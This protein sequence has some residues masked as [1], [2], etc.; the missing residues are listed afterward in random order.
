VL[1][2]KRVVTN[3]KFQAGLSSIGLSQYYFHKRAG[4]NIYLK[5]KKGTKNQYENFL[6]QLE[7]LSQVLNVENLRVKR[8]GENGVFL[9]SSIVFALLK[10]AAVIKNSV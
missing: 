3:S 1:I 10:I 6:N 9:Y 5:F 7:N 2:C 4:H 8:Y